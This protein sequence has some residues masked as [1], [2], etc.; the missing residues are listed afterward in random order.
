[1]I[2]DGQRKS[3]RRGREKNE[4]LKLL[5]R[6]LAGSEPTEDD[7]L[8]VL[9]LVQPRPEPC[10]ASLDRES[11]RP[12]AAR[13]VKTTVHNKALIGELSISKKK[14]AAFLNAMGGEVPEIFIDEDVSYG[15][16]LQILGDVVSLIPFIPNSYSMTLIECMDVALAS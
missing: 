2:R 9:S 11:L 7:V 6:A 10:Q 4:R 16:F 8:D 3:I 5:F 14:L 13:L 12:M 1:V 15:D